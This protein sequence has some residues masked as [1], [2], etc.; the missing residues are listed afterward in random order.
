MDS[1]LSSAII[2]LLFMV[3]VLN[4]IVWNL[5]KKVERIETLITSE[6]GIYLDR[7]TTNLRV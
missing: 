1:F 3:S 4:I 6:E 7:M 2:V 5:R